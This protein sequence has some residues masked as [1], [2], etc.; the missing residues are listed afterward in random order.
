MGELKTITELHCTLVRSWHTK[1][2]AFHYLQGLFLD[3]GNFARRQDGRGGGPDGTAG[4]LFHLCCGFEAM[5]IILMWAKCRH[6]LWQSPRR[7]IIRMR[8]RSFR[9][10]SLEY[11]FPFAFPFVL[12][13]ACVLFCG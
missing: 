8:I 7:G 10:D 11:Y 5:R 4:T 12:M 1:K 6:F 9:R 3:C 2:Q 13:H